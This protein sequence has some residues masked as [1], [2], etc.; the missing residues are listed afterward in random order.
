MAQSAEIEEISAFAVFTDLKEFTLIR[1]A[2]YPEFIDVLRQ[3]FGRIQAET[4]EAIVFN[5]W[6][7]A[8]FAVFKTAAPAVRWML[9]YR[10]AYRHNPTGR[11]AA[12]TTE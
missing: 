9:E 1:Q 7:D 8:C 2:A 4:D 11:T 3:V 10:T 5:T 12:Q 6:G